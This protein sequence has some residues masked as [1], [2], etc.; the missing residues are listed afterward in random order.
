MA[1]EAF[2]IDTSERSIVKVTFPATYTE[3]ELTDGLAELDGIIRAQGQQPWSL[4]IDLSLRS[5]SSS[6]TRKVL[7]DW[8]REREALFRSTCRGWALVARNQLV[9]GA[10]TAIFWIMKPGWP[11]QVVVE[12][13][14]AEALAR[15]MLT[16]APA[17]ARPTA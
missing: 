17:D 8:I 15:S 14:E 9:R 13:E 12:R 6:I 16:A 3:A 1:T 2:I 11:I 4:V 7:A 5:G 10:I